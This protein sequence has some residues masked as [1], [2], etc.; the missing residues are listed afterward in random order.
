MSSARLETLH[1][2]SE[3]KDGINNSSTESSPSISVTAA[4]SPTSAASSVTKNSARTPSSWDAEDDVLLMHLKDKQKLGWKE[5]ASNFTNRTPNA[6]QFRWRRLKSG[7]LKN[8]PKSASQLG[9]SFKQTSG[10]ISSTST[11][12]KKKSTNSNRTNTKIETTESEFSYSPVTSGG[13]QGFD[14]N[15]SSALAGLNALSNSPS[16]IS[17]SSATTTPKISVSS[18][19]INYGGSSGRANS[20]SSLHHHKYEGSST[21]DNLMEPSGKSVIVAPGTSGSGGYYADVSVDPTMNLPHNQAHPETSSSVTPRG[22]LSHATNNSGRQKDT[23]NSNNLHTESISAAATA[24][25]ALRNNSIIQIASEDRESI[26]SITRASVSSLPSKS[27][28]IPHH[29]S[30]SSALAHLPVLFGGAGSISGP[31]RNPSI[32]GMSGHQTT[33][34]SLRNGSLVA[35]NTGYYSRSGSVVIPHNTDKSEEPL[36][37]KDDKVDNHNTSTNTNANNNHN[38]NSNNNTNNKNNNKL[39]KL[40]RN[41]P[42]AANSSHGSGK[43]KGKGKGKEKEKEKEKRESSK[44]DIPWTME[45]DELLINR[46]NRELSFA[47]LSI[48]LPQRTEGEI[49]SRIDYLEK[50]RNGNDRTVNARERRKSRQSSFGL[51]D[52]NDLYDDDDDDVIGGIGISDDEDDNELLVDINDDTVPRLRNKKRRTSSAVNPLSVRST[53]RKG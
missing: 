20:I 32:S 35:A 18:P 30:G 48:L 41:T 19:R 47:E 36:K 46:R 24:A 14:N 39:H 51:D 3:N 15:I 2:A 49:W 44:L 37:V 50:L 31:S 38:N 5:I 52:V 1:L 45:E 8:P 16:Y 4:N 34:S 27:M 7:N 12:K 9:E 23:S 26:S 17:S 53:I 40:K 13:F 22:S 6:C 28:N 29:Q 11:S 33:V 21:S 10:V 42:T 25:A 43:G